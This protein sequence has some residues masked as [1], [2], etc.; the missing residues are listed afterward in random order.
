MA[1]T[2]AQRDGKL[3]FARTDHC[4]DYLRQILMAVIPLALIQVYDFLL[5][6]TH[7]CWGDLTPAT[8]SVK[9]GYDPEAQTIRIFPYVQDLQVH[10]CRNFD[11][12][13]EWAEKANSSGYVISKHPDFLRG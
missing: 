2:K 7:R 13:H 8:F 9:P 1:S 5:I 4:I 12:I 10:M 3:T 11:R 6:P